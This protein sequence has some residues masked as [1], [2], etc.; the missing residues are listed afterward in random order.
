MSESLPDPSLDEEEPGDTNPRRNILLIAIAAVVLIICGAAAVLFLLLRDEDAEPIPT[1]I[2]T[3][4]S[5]EPTATEPGP[6][7]AVDQ[8]W[9]KIQASGTL[10]I[11]TSADYPPFEYYTDDFRLDG[12]DIALI[13]E[14]GNI[15][16]LEVDISDMAFDGLGGALQVNQ[17]DVA[18]A[19]MTVT[20]EREQFVDFSNIYF[21]SEDAALAMGGSQIRV[22]SAEELAA[23]RLGVG[24][25]TIYED[26]VRTDLIETGLMPAGN[27]HVYA[28][29][30]QA[31]NELE[32]EQID[33]VLLDLATADMAAS[34]MGFTLAGSGNNQL[35]IAMAVPQDSFMLRSELNRALAELQIEGRVAE[36][37]SEYFDIEQEVIPPVPTPESEE[38]TP[39][40]PTSIGCID[41]MDYVADLSYDDGGF[42]NI[43]EVPA[44]TAFQKGWRLRNSGTCTWDNSYSLVPVEGSSPAARMGGLPIPVQSIVSPGQTYDFFTNLTAPIKPGTYVE[45]WTMRNSDGGLFGDRVWVA[46]T[47]PGVPTPTP[48]PTSTPSPE[49]SFSAN[50]E[51]I[52]QGQCSTLTWS[53]ENVRTVYVYPQGANWQD[54]GVPGIGSQTVCPQETTTYEMR[55]VKMDG[56]VEIRRVTVYVIPNSEAPQIVFFT[57]EPPGTIELGQCVLIRWAVE[58]DVTSINIWR[59]DVP[60]RTNAPLSGQMS[61]CPPNSGQ[62]VYKIEATGSG[63]TSVSSQTVHV[64]SS[65]TPTRQPTNTPVP[66]ATP[67]TPPDVPTNTPAPTATSTI[68][69]PTATATAVPPTATPVPDPIIYSFTAIP[70]IV[71]V[72]QCV[73]LNWSVGGNTDLVQILKESRVIYDDAPLRGSETDCDL[74]SVGT[75][76]YQIR[77]SN[78]AGG[79]ASDGATVQV[80]EEIPNDPLD[81]TSW[82]LVSYLSSGQQTELLEGTTVTA[83]FTSGQVAGTS[84][85]NTYG[86]AYTVDENNITIEP[87]LGTNL[88]C[89]EPAGI[90]Q[91]EAVYQALLPTS[92]TYQVRNETFIISDVNGQAIL[93][94]AQ[95]VPTPAQ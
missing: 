53:T 72:G 7:A 69:P 49:I 44:G 3:V 29:M 62:F 80:V 60:L 59:N 94:F 78:S 63:G 86:A 74:S 54:F 84:G 65:A 55:V 28:R 20:D 30:D 26:F 50:P 70:N 76:T 38:P 39:T 25:G 75:V 79:M 88:F 66:T 82:T 81:G 5:S 9:A 34:E 68:V 11:G 41:A 51:T 32:M 10:L 61:D 1:L 85:C 33:L 90:M 71:T 58:G 14:I 31:L 56:S 35:R 48:L 52:Q 73:T 8:V 92:A 57:V 46:I 19:A 47:V 64:A 18:I 24:S 95:L 37:I 42:Q 6:D 4:V 12:F 43:P 23:Y 87:P 22:T 77:A 13:R 21:I 83:S 27:L 17:I 93:T 40:P 16:G 2:P 91:Q 67:T 89:S 45:Y 36:L 15:L